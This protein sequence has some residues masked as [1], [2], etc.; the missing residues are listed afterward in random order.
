MEETRIRFLGRYLPLEES[1]ATRSSILAWRILWT[2]EPGGLQSIASQRVRHNLRDWGGMDRQTFLLFGIKLPPKIWLHFE[3]YLKIQMNALYQ[4][5]SSDGHVRNCCPWDGLLFWRDPFGAT[6]LG[7]TVRG[8][9]HRSLCAAHCVCFSSSYTCFIP[10][11][12]P[13]LSAC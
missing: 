4:I 11:E 2:E 9:P 5:L 8:E 10:S 3:S 7:L 1:M 6:H 13:S 12:N